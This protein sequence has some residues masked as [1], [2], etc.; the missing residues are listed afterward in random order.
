[1][2]ECM[3]ELFKDSC[4]QVDKRT[5]LRYDG[6]GRAIN[7]IFVF[8]GGD[9]GVSIG[10]A[11]NDGGTHLKSVSNRREGIKSETDKPSR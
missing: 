6:L 4:K 8:Q 1:M 11:G 5:H 2:L 10:A 7:N 3:Q 9:I